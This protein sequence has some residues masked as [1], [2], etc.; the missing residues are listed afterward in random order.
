MKVK[1]WIRIRIKE[2]SLIRTCIK[3]TR[4]RY[5]G[6]NQDLHQSKKQDPDKGI[7]MIRIR[8]TD[9][10]LQFSIFPVWK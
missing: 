8:N 10:K 5:P 9:W 4:I 1:S 7:K 3:V 6:E 2:E